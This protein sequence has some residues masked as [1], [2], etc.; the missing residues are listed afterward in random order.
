[1]DHLETQTTSD[2]ELGTRDACPQEASGVLPDINEKSGHTDPSSSECL[3][4]QR[5]KGT[6][7]L[8]G[9]V[10]E[11]AAWTHEEPQ[12][13][14]Q[15]PAPAGP[16]NAPVSSPL[17]A[18]HTAAASAAAR[19][20]QD[21]PQPPPL[22]ILRS[23]ALDAGRL[24]TELTSLLGEQLS[25]V[26]ALFNPGRV[27]EWDAEI[28]AVLNLLVFGASVWQSPTAATPGSALLNLKYRSEDAPG[29]ALLPTGLQ[30]WVGPSNATE[31]AGTEVAETEGLQSKQLTEIAS[32]EVAGTDGLQSKR[33]AEVADTEVAVTGGLQSK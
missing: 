28:N 4:S 21:P 33:L 22:H 30:H 20:A 16:L 7:N 6:I 25:K 26:F 17:H 23:S 31:V 14:Q 15:A 1:M 18:A 8:E 13:F 10:N 2:P 9:N 12:E 3:V 24:D 29:A 5:Q 32:T 27:M 19:A 11:Q